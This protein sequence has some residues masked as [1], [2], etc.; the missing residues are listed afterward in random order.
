M[1]IKVD[2]TFKASS[3]CNN[4]GCCMIDVIPATAMEVLR[5]IKTLCDACDTWEDCESFG[6]PFYNKAS[7]IQPCM[8]NV[9][10]DTLEITEEN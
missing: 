8:I 3:Y 6:C 4:C 2:D 9:P 1:T 5:K 10:S 7:T